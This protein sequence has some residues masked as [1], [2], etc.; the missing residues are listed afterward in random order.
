M[1]WTLFDLRRFLLQRH[2]RLRWKAILSALRT[3]D[4]TN[5]GDLQ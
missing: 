2:S 3:R 1:T 5:F 4:L